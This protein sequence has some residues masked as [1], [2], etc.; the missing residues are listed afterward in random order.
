MTEKAEHEYLA[1]VLKIE[2]VENVKNNVCYTVH[3]KGTQKHS[4]CIICE[5]FD[6][7]DSKCHVQKSTLFTV[8]L[9]FM[10]LRSPKSVDGS[11]VLVN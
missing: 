2:P 6:P 4:F 8:N 7:L 3:K 11:V 5:Y 9:T 10:T 1:Y